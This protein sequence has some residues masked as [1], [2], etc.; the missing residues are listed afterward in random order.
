[1]RALIFLLALLFSNAAHAQSQWVGPAA[2]GNAP[3]MLFTN[4]ASIL[5]GHLGTGTGTPALTSCG[6]SPTIA[7]SDMAGLVTLGT[8]T[9]TGCVITFSVAYTNAPFC[10]VTWQATPL[11]SQ[12]YSVSATAITLTQT[13]ASSDKVNYVCFAQNGG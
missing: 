9:P 8:G 12:S 3:G 2:P 7:G 4:G 1:M 6:T 13:A 11:A 10:V 5:Y